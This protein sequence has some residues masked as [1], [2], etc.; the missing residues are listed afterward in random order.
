MFDFNSY[1]HSV[2][3]DVPPYTTVN[4]HFDHKK[5][6]KK[7]NATN[8]VEHKKILSGNNLPPGVKT[9]E[10]LVQYAKKCF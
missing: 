2:P 1:S 10:N 5:E 3:V 7:K 6:K 8:F 4:Q 9:K